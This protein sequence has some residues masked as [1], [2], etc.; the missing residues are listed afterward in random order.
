MS[1][2]KLSSHSSHEQHE[3]LEIRERAAE[4]TLSTRSPVQ[5][6]Q[7]VLQDRI[8]SHPGGNHPLLREATDLLQAISETPPVA[9]FEWRN[10]TEFYNS[11]LSLAEL[12]NIGLTFCDPAI[13]ES[14]SALVQQ[15]SSEGA[16]FSAIVLGRYMDQAESVYEE[17]LRACP[18]FSKTPFEEAP[19]HKYSFFSR[20]LAFSG[21]TQKELHERSLEQDKIMERLRKHIEN[22]KDP[23][24]AAILRPAP[25]DLVKIYGFTMHGAARSD[26]LIFIHRK[27]PQAE[28]KGCDFY[29][30]EA[31]QK[32]A[33]LRKLKRGGRERA[34]DEITLVEQRETQQLSTRLTLGPSQ[35]SERR[36]KEK[37]V[38][39]TRVFF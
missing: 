35:Q 9:Y 29:A 24:I 11:R 14:S 16:A 12:M 8:S 3:Q 2:S 27:V 20:L 30:Q 13:Y 32:E 21:G 23:A 39:K 33:E 36:A 19:S 26:A 10:R 1:I 7:L 28:Q 15:V 6:V 22:L 5:N 18:Q 4:V 25:Y 38:S 17:L 34:R 37:T 31:K